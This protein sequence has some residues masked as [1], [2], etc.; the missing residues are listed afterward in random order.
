MGVTIIGVLLFILG[1]LMLL[2]GLGIAVLS[3]SID[4][5]GLELALG[6]FAAILGLIYLICG[7]GFLRGWNWVWYLTVLVL[8]IGAIM[9]VVQMVTTTSLTNIIGLVVQ[10]VILLY[11][12]SKKVKDFFFQ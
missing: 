5:E 3:D 6:G 10:I 7:V 4:L 11:M 12:N 2:G 1:S 9:N 8:I